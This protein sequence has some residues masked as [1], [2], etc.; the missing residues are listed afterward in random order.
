MKL[1]NGRISKLL[2]ILLA[3]GLLV[4]S[5]PQS[6]LDADAEELAEAFNEEDDEYD[7]TEQSGNV[8]VNF[9]G[10]H[11]TVYDYDDDE[12]EITEVEVYK[13]YSGHAYIVPE[14]GY[15]ISQIATESDIVS[16]SSCWN[17]CNQ[18]GRYRC[19]FST[20]TVES[21]QS[22]T[23]QVTTV[24]TANQVLSL[25]YS[26]DVVEEV[27]LYNNDEQVSINAAKQATVSNAYGNKIYL[28]M[29]DEKVPI[30]TIRRG[31]DSVEELT[32]DSVDDSGYYHCFLGKA[33]QDETIS[34]TAGESCTITLGGDYTNMVRIVPH[35]GIDSWE[36]WDEDIIPPPEEENTIQAVVGKTLYFYAYVSA[37]SWKFTTDSTGGIT[38][39]SIKG[40]GTVYAVTPLGDTNVDLVT[41]AKEIPVSYTDGVVKNLQIV[42]E[43]EDEEEESTTVKAELVDE[44][45]LVR[46]YYEDD[47]QFSF[48]LA[49][50][51]VLGRVYYIEE[52]KEKDDGSEDYETVEYKRNVATT[53]DETKEQYTFWIPTRDATEIVIEAGMSC[54]VT[55]EYDEDYLCF[56]KYKRENCRDYE[57]DWAPSAEWDSWDDF[58]AIVAV[59]TPFGFFVEDYLYIGSYSLVVEPS[60][61]ITTL[62]KYTAS[63]DDTEG[64]AYEITP[65]KDTTIKVLSVAKKIPLT[66]TDGAI[67]IQ[68]ATTDNGQSIEVAEDGT[69][70]NVY[71]QEDDASICFSMADGNTL[72]H[73]YRYYTDWDDDEKAFTNKKELT[74]TGPDATGNYTFVVDLDED[75]EKI[76]FVTESSTVAKETVTISATELQNQMTYSKSPVQCYSDIRVTNSNGDDITE[77]LRSELLVSY[78]GRE[79][80][81][82][83]ASTTAPVHAG[84]Y[85]LKIAVPSDNETYKGSVSYDFEITPKQTKVTALNYT[86]KNT[87]GHPTAESYPGGYEADLVSG[88][89]LT[90]APTYTYY[91]DSEMS[92][93]V[94]EED[95]AALENG[96]VVWVKPGNA[97]AGS[98]YEITEY[99]PGKIT[100]FVPGE[101][102]SIED[103]PEQTYSGNAVKPTV[104]VLG[105]D[106]DELKAGK[107]YT[108]KYYNNVNA[109]SK[110]S[111]SAAGSEFDSSLPYVEITGIGNYEGTIRKNFRILPVAIDDG[112]G[113]P[114]AGITLKY[115][116]QFVVGKKDL[117]PLSSIKYKAAMKAGTDYD[118]TIS[119]DNYK[120]TNEGTKLPVITK[121]AVGTYTLT[122]S[123]KGNYT[124]AIE[125]TIYV[126][127]AEEPAKLMKNA[128][129][130]LGK[131]LKSVKFSD[132][133]DGEVTLTPA[134]EKGDDVFVV[135]VGKGAAATV[136]QYNANN[137]ESEYLIEYTNNDRVGTAT[138]TITGNPA[139]GYVGSK[140]VTFKITGTPFNERNVSVSDF[141]DSVIYSGEPIRQDKVVLTAATSGQAAKTFVQGEDYT[142]TYKNNLKKGTA[143]VT[144]TAKPESGYVGKF[145]KKF[146]IGAVELKDLAGIAYS[147]DNEIWNDVTQS[148]DK[149]SIADALSYDIAG[150]TPSLRLV[151]QEGN[152]LKAGTDYTVKYTNNKSVTTS[153]VAENKHPGIVIKGKGNYAGTLNIGFSICKSS[154]DAVQT[155]VTALAYNA[156]K[157]DSFAYKPKL[158]IMNG[159]KA[160]SSKDYSVEYQNNTQADVKAYL[161][162]LNGGNAAAQPKAVITIK[163]S[164]NFYDTSA[165]EGGNTIEVPLEI[166]ETKL[167]KKNLDV[168]VT[169][170]TTYTGEQLQPEIT[171]SVTDKGNTTVLKENKD[172]TITYGA[173]VT[174]GKNKGSVTITGKGL[175]GG[176]VTYKF[177][178]ARSSVK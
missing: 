171:V 54:T 85:T 94:K 134:M 157:A 35:G 33:Y 103:I 58:T 59:G 70:V 176:S 123:G 30:V 38:K 32:F 96:A 48:Q 126:V 79:G 11:F 113:N 149:L 169:G 131:N 63:E 129:I 1:K 107:D 56:Y 28:K 66:Y 8:T 104:V 65:Q 91:K 170:D 87:V 128:T 86:W 140:S 53:Y 164:S 108:V 133:T 69:S 151:D 121:G 156:K 177:D 105:A 173:N 141:A 15:T 138:M 10:E 61:D 4:T 29:K 102:M 142:V 81:E 18:A 165:A 3:A 117:Q 45:K 88:D 40:H 80:T 72:S 73:V 20:Q 114:A 145:N 154:K 64:F 36:Q 95:W 17:D 112:E 39:Q 167:T 19:Y 174:A 120:A 93:E 163:E 109:S 12:T 168:Q 82:Y 74:V 77:T 119:G 67:Q 7:E 146:K 42:T 83:S 143:T 137:D 43:Q 125:K 68:K 111:D 34:I 92:V 132:Y 25:E 84:K 57:G 100:V 49:S 161:A 147:E 46:A 50:E 106:G 139:K 155:S 172:Y 99:V 47:L 116:D 51:N 55:L 24:P 5:V 23:V 13:G 166:Y 2:S 135:T 178:I 152:V 37:P 26:S 153:A 162:Y 9:S 71:I 130:T 98:D 52:V 78:E 158:K 14:T 90:A 44:D 159:K 31:D 75:I 115:T 110:A 21:N 144:F 16:V 118:V 160:L 124:G 60:I 97:N 22:A 101:T 89:V 136:L 76:E 127:S 27:K 62:R 148:G 41:E 175:Y 122:I 150:V 6:V